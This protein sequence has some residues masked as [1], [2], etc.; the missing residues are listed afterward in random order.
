MLDPSRVNERETGLVYLP[1]VGEEWRGEEASVFGVFLEG[2]GQGVEG[3]VT[4]GYG[5]AS[6]FG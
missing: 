5:E 4:G 2:V 3:F 6:W 1:T